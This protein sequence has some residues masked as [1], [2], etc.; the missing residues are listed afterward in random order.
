MVVVG[1]VRVE[2]LA[3]VVG[4]VAGLL[5]PEGEIG[6][7]EALFDEFRV[8]AWERLLVVLFFAC[9]WDRKR[10]G[11]V[12]RVH[13]SDVGVVCQLAGPER[14]SGGAANGRGAVVAL[15]EGALVSEMLLDQ[16]QII[17]RLHV[18]VLV[19]CQDEHNV[20]LLSLRA[21]SPRVTEA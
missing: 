21:G 19:I 10:N 15:I 17:Q 1:G 11:T 14:D 7:V 18:Q 16:R 2:E 12:G 9:A 5:E 8:A 3:R 6:R 4:V 20:R 13:V